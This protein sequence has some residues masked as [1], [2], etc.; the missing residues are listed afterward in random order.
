MSECFKER[1]ATVAVLLDGRHHICVKVREGEDEEGVE[2][3]VKD[4]IW[5]P[6]ARVKGVYD[7][8]WDK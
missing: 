5:G 7:T 1:W 2:R 6:P 3:R 8:P 4:S